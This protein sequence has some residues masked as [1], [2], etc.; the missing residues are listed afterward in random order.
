MPPPKG[1]RMQMGWAAGAL[2]DRNF[3]IVECLRNVASAGG[4]SMLDLA[5]SWLLKNAVV[6]SV[7]A[8]ATRPEQIRANARAAGWTIS[9]NDLAAIDRCY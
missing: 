6:A 1:T 3:A 2:T 9:K 5:F 4:H 8:G 7:I